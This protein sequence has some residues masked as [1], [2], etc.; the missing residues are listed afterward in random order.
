LRLQKYVKL[1][2][3]QTLS[4]EIFF[5]IPMWLDYQDTYSNSRL[6]FRMV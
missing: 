4:K 3:R 1:F 2:Y 6:L 5:V